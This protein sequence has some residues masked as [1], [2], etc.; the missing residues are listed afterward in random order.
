MMMIVSSLETNTLQIFISPPSRLTKMSLIR[1][2]SALR[3]C[4]GK[5]CW[6]TNTR[7]CRLKRAG[8]RMPCASTAVLHT[9][10]TAGESL[11]GVPRPHKW[12]NKAWFSTSRDDDGRDYYVPTFADDSLD[13]TTGHMA[14]TEDEAVSIAIPGS[15]TGGRKLVIVFTCAVCDARSAKQ[16]TERAYNHGVVI[17]RCPGCSNLHLIAD[18]LGY[19]QDGDFDLKSIAESRGEKIKTVTEDNVLEITLEDLVGE[20]KMNELLREDND[21][22]EKRP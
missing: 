9:R 19:F 14:T 13:E 4:S 7:T 16:F 3:S 1:T 12:G 20:E 10:F 2:Q 8:F 17:V 15:Q 21:D 5:Y 6:Q 22:E 18:R 11:L